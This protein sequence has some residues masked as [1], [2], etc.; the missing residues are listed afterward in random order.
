MRETAD[1]IGIDRLLALTKGA[2]PQTASEKGWLALCDYQKQLFE[3]TWP[4]TLLVSP[5][6]D[7]TGLNAFREDLLEQHG[8]SQR[9]PV[10]PGGP[11][12]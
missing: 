10:I 2:S 1:A 8:N 4:E 12:P 6:C 5:T 3:T 11:T 7:P 9:L